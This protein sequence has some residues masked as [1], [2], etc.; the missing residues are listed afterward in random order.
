MDIPKNIRRY[1][2][3]FVYFIHIID[4]DIFLIGKTASIKLTLNKIQSET[5]KK[6]KLYNIIKVDNIDGDDDNE[7]DEELSKVYIRFHKSRID[8]ERF[9]ISKCDIDKYIENK[10]YN[11][12]INDV[13]SI[14]RNINENGNGNGNDD[15]IDND[16]DGNQYICRRCEQQFKRKYNYKRHLTRRVPCQSSNKITNKTT[17]KMDEL[18][19]QLVNNMMILK[20]L[21]I[22]EKEIKIKNLKQQNNELKT[23][24]KKIKKKNKKLSTQ[25][26]SQPIHQSVHLYDQRSVNNTLNQNNIYTTSNSVDVNNFGKEDIEYIDE[27]V[28]NNCLLDGQQGNVRLF[29][30][31]HMH[32]EHPEN[33]NVIYII[34]DDQFLAF[35]SGNWHQTEKDTIARMHLQKA[36]KIY[37]KHLTNK[38]DTIHQISDEERIKYNETSSY[39]GEYKE[40]LISNITNRFGEKQIEYP[41]SKLIK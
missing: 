26:T 8:D 22:Q 18:N 5:S 16:F 15:N 28:I 25:I 37:R 7:I 3:N 20:E 23:K 40:E 11:N 21:K 1:K 6:I 2:G 19:S 9:H 27:N 4:D 35:E 39:D 32:P 12:L 14:S 33:H 41:D 31:I 38:A 24:N 36:I 30:E 13:D 17:N 34:D 29:Q 10:E